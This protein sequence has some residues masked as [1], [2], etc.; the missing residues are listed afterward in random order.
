[1]MK[2]IGAYQLGEILYEGEQSRIFR[3]IRKEDG[4]PVILKGIHG[5]FNLP[6]EHALKNEWQ[7]SS[8]IPEGVAPECL[9][10]IDEGP[11]LVK[12]F[13]EG[14]SLGQR[15]PA[16]GFELDE[17]FSLSEKMFTLLA[18]LQ[19]AGIVHGDIRPSNLLLFDDK[20][21]MVLLDFGHAFLRHSLRDEEL[22]HDTSREGS[23][24]Y[25]SP[26]QTGRLEQPLDYRSD[27][28]SAGISL[29][30]MLLGFPPF[31]GNIL[32][33]VHGHI[34]VKPE[35]PSSIKPEIPE[36][37]SAIILKLLEKNPE[38][39]YSSAEGVL[40]DLAQV[41]EFTRM[42]GKG[43]LFI[44]G[45]SDPASFFSL[46]NKLV[47]R[48][49]ELASLHEAINR[50]R[51]R[52]A[53]LLLLAG[54]SGLGKSALLREFARREQRDEQPFW[55]VYTGWEDP[56]DSK[57][58]GTGALLKAA[59]DL[60][61]RI[62]GAH[63]DEIASW[64]SMIRNEIGD[65]VSLLR[66]QIPA[67]SMIIGSSAEETAE[68]H[69]QLGEQLGD[70]KSG[71]KE[72]RKLEQ[73]LLSF[74]RL[75]SAWGEGLVLV[76]DDLHLAEREELHIL[77]SLLALEIEHPLLVVSSYQPE[78]IGDE[79]RIIDILSE[80]P[81]ELPV[82]TMLLRGLSVDAVSLWLQ[83]SFGPSPQE[84]H[85]QAELL[86][87]K[88]SGNPFHIRQAVRYLF[89]EG[90]LFY[91][92]ER[93]WSWKEESMNTLE[94]FTSIR[95]LLFHHLEQLSQPERKLLA[96]LLLLNMRT[97]E[98]ELSSICGDETSPSVL[99][100]LEGFGFILRKSDGVEALGGKSR[101]R[102]LKEFPSGFINDIR[103]QTGRYLLGQ[104][105]SREK[106]TENRDSGLEPLMT[107]ITDILLQLPPSLLTKEEAL[108]LALISLDLG[109][110]NLAKGNYERAFQYTHGVTSLLPLEQIESDITLYRSLHEIRARSFHLQGEFE[111][112]LKEYQ[113]LLNRTDDGE[114]VMA[115]YGEMIEAYSLLSRFH[116]ALEVGEKAF[117]L[118]GIDFLN[119]REGRS[120]ELDQILESVNPDHVT[121]LP[122]PEHGLYRK[123]L[124][125][126]VNLDGSIYSQRPEAYGNFIKELMVFILHHGGG[127]E[128]SFIFSLYALHLTGREYQ[129][130]QAEL[131]GRAALQLSD[132]YRNNRFRVMC[133]EVYGA[134]VAPWTIP[135]V[136]IGPIFSEG[137]ALGKISGEVQFT[138]YIL[139]HRLVHEFFL[140]TDFQELKHLGE[141]YERLAGSMRNQEAV[142]HLEGV[143]AVISL[144]MAKDSTQ[145]ESSLKRVREVENRAEQHG[146]Y[147]ALVTAE[148]FMLLYALLFRYT[149]MA[150]RALERV[151]RYFLHLKEGYL[152]APVLMAKGL[153]ALEAEK[154]EEAKEM[155]SLLSLYAQGCKENY[156][157]LLRLLEAEIS[158]HITGEDKA[159]E[160]LFEEAI[161]AARQNGDLFHTALANERYA[162]YL[163]NQEKS[164][165]GGLYVQEA[166]R[167]WTYLGVPE[168]ATRL[169][170]KWGSF[171]PGAITLTGSEQESSGGVEKGSSYGVDVISLMKAGRELTSTLSEELLVERFLK[172]VLENTGAQKAFYIVIKND[173]L[174]LRGR[175]L[176]ETGEFT[177]YPLEGGEEKIERLVRSINLSIGVLRYVK[178]SGKRVVLDDAAARGDFINDPYFRAIGIRSVF[179]EPLEDTGF[180]RSMIYLENSVV[181]ALFSPPRIEIVELLSRQ[182]GTALQNVKLYEQSRLLNRNLQEEVL[183]RSRIEEE[184]EERVEERTREV[185]ESKRALE[186]SYKDLQDAQDTLI[187]S[188]KLAGLG[189]LVAGI[190]HEVN[191]PLGVA[192]TA[193]S[194]LT[195]QLKS[196]FADSETLLE[197]VDLLMRN[198]NKAADLIGSF[199]KVAV[200]QAGEQEREFLLDT[201]IRDVMV[202]LQPL[203]RKSRV[204]VSID[205]PE[206]IRVIGKPGALSQ[207]IGN[208]VQNS[209]I[210][211][212]PDG[213]S[214]TIRISAAVD[215]QQLALVHEDNGKGMDSGTVKKVFDPFFTT[216]RGSGG[217]G[218]GMNIV[219]NL[220]VKSLQGDISC[221]S[222]PGEG[223]RFTIRFPLQ[224]A[225]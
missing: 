103:L 65:S 123:F 74:L 136:D 133:R 48:E 113:L 208:L 100:K 36:A 49:S 220:V 115:Y 42:P 177:F 75:F 45:K 135:L 174:L 59:A 2:Q 132:S 89:Q 148:G 162:I 167:F 67:L 78:G 120:E 138:G 163:M 77:R 29:Y 224:P 204:E 26:E 157:H 23:P 22:H 216:R 5:S 142:D 202:S 129:F 137:V 205:I 147:Q 159:G 16:S 213:E 116:Q 191:T 160:T 24:L 14:T 84:Y 19:G 131:F 200:D 12:P 178:R 71:I 145:R 225:R 168:R 97:P 68:E 107:Q 171:F 207:I 110:R 192:V 188:E 186:K 88:F 127:A 52:G 212:F 102:L 112:S 99:D 184:L 64:A 124:Q 61:Y 3:G 57:K 105:S 85:H 121:L 154:I 150:E 92:K 82:S 130:G 70:K 153:F 172:L 193:G 86:V 80:L 190:A 10:W 203:L 111:A 28:Y 222:E 164:R 31:S 95:L 155:A 151:E 106:S 199:K 50:S 79:E 195:D 46:S 210:H 223:V 25:I 219:Y 158:L 109:R 51:E 34:A 125:A 43:K 139:M 108:Q 122:Q 87:E 143:M 1:M 39:R 194:F 215:G 214:G 15:I 98:K 201:Y 166:Y 181:P 119:S 117:A 96:C 152:V 165:V 7:L 218:L 187:E 149:G 128:S 196:G 185:L 170:Q 6:A 93:G 83:R 30:E 54:E 72:G 209:L 169:R 90:S 134:H 73:A 176:G 11:F 126:A 161:E 35:S 144:F 17:W 91:T 76:L 58:K 55:V 94:G 32:E 47:A 20:H 206:G 221:E 175:Y 156:L 140:T 104:L 81:V 18:K 38:D 180:G 101:K 60:V 198:L 27:Y 189:S 183:R 63:E 8:L 4:L 62:L 9:D 53:E 41:K 40:N 66:Q 141:E 13:L 21:T 146:N 118:A 197:S 179:C 37:V 69:E 56:S 33:V 173:E 114:T 182:A 44:P 211:G 217:S